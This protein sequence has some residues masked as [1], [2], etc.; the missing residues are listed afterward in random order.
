MLVAFVCNEITRGII[1]LTVDE[2]LLGIHLGPH[3][4]KST[5]WVSS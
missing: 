4:T 1:L 3:T 2:T 5:D